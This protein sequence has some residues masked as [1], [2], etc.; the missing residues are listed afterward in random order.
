WMG[1]RGCEQPAH[2]WGGL[3]S[4]PLSLASATGT[5]RTPIKSGLAASKMYMTAQPSMPHRACVH[6][7]RAT[8]PCRCSTAPELARVKQLLL[9]RGAA[10]RSGRCG[11]MI[12]TPHGLQPS[13][14]SGYAP[15][16]PSR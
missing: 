10:M 5:N 3:K 1:A 2:D 16:T 4:E 8:I 15:G 6:D 7:D 14:F 12:D 9:P 11:M 13:G